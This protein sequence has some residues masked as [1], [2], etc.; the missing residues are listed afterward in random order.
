M[1]RTDEALGEKQLVILSRNLSQIVDSYRRDKPL[2]DTAQRMVSGADDDLKSQTSTKLE[3][4]KKG[5]TQSSFHNP[6]QHKKN[7]TLP[8]T[9][10]FQDVITAMTS[11]KGIG[12]TEG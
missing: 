7:K 9:S 10:T 4:S 2:T 5:N 6:T 11:N 8:N 3:A 1:V 12:M